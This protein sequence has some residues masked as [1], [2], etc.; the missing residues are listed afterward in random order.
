LYQIE[1]ILHI[2]GIVEPVLGNSSNTI[3]PL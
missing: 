1:K 3:V 2:L